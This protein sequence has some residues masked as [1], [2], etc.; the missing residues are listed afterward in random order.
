[1]K[2][3]FIIIFILFSFVT[4]NLYAKDFFYEIYGLNLKFMEIQFS[5]SP[6]QELATKIKSK[7]L[8]NFFVSFRGNGSTKANTEQTSYQFQYQKKKKA[9]STTIIF[10]DKKV[11]KNV[12]R[13]ARKKQTN[14]IP[15][16]SYHLQDVMDPLTAL[17]QLLFN[18]T[19]KLNCNQK[20]K[21]FDGSDVFYLILSRQKNNDQIFN[22]SKITF[23]KLL[24]KCKMQ[25]QTIAGHKAKDEKKFNKSYVDIFYG[26][27]DMVYLPY[28]LRTKAKISLKMFLK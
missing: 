12:S 14:I 3:L 21:V 24:R 20:I 11:I 10:K 17:N 9:R 26:K 25:Y 15:I 22:S 4:Q 8:L 19:N 13:P 1:M 16:Q 28:F 7:G 18:Q 27:H 6:H 2:K 23:K 5:N